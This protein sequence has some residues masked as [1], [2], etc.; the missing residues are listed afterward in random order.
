MDLKPYSK[1][2]NYGQK[3]E[4]INDGI[5][6]PHTFVRVV[7]VDKKVP[8]LLCGCRDGALCF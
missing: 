2:E 1:T 3:W 4:R 7:R 5:E 6:D 8:G